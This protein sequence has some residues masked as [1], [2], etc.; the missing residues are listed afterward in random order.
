MKVD[1]SGLDV[2]GIVTQLDKTVES[3]SEIPLGLPLV[4][5]WTWDCICNFYKDDECLMKPKEDVLRAMLEQ[6]GGGFTLEYGTEHHYESVR[7]WLITN[8]LM[9]Y[10]EMCESNPPHS[11]DSKYCE[12]CAREYKESENE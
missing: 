2:S 8:E 7:D 3:V 4:W 9:L 5:L 1:I 10:C 6:D 11:I 12:A